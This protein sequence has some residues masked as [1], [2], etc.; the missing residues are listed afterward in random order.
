MPIV[1]NSAQ[2]LAPDERLHFRDRLRAAR[3]AALADAEGFSEICFAIEALGV[4]VAG[5][6]L[7]LGR[8]RLGIQ[9]YWNELPYLEKLSTRFPQLF[10][11]FDAL[12][13]S[14]QAAR[15][16]AMHTGAYARHVTT[17]AIE[18]CIGLEASLMSTPQRSSVSDFMVK[19]AI[20]V[21]EWQPVARA[22]QLMLTHSFTYLPAFIDGQWK[23]ISELAVARFLR[24]GG[25]PA[26]LLGMQISMASKTKNA[27]GTEFTSLER[28]LPLEVSTPL[29]VNVADQ[30]DSLLAPDVASLTPSLWLVKGHDAGNLSGVLSPFELM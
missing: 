21:E 23:L 30:V 10:T 29:L 28:P 15:N 22:R 2:I 3:Y 8:Y 20:I 26:H 11:R 13:E 4:R 25:S 7:A 16:D 14:L 17:A 12:Y 5:R 27:D 24:S 6:R 19:D 9:A 1:Q 18:L